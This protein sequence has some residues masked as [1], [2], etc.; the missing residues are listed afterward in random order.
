MAKNLLIATL[1]T[2]PAV[3]TEAVDL[4]AEQEIRLDG[5]ILFV[6]QDRDV[7]DSFQLLSEHLPSHDGINRN[8][9]QPFPVAAYE[10]IRTSEAAVE[11]MQEACHILKAYR[12]NGDRLFVC[13][14]GGRKAMSSL[15]VLAAQFYGAE[16][17]FHIWAPPWMEAEGEIGRLRNLQ[18]EQLNKYLH[19]S[20]SE[21][22]SDRPHIVVL[23]FIGLFPLLPDILNAFKGQTS[24]SKEVKAML[25]GNGLLTQGGELTSLGQRVA[26]ILDHVENLP[27]ARQSEYKIHIA[28]HHYRDKL[29]RFA[30]KLA[31]RF[32]FVTEIRSGEWQQGEEQVKPEPPSSLI[33]STRLGTDILFRLR[34]VTT[35][36]SPGQ[37]EAA[38]Q[39]VESYLKAI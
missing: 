11:F 26:K 1:G 36:R 12:D 31:E 15:L 22:E 37:L 30:K 17:L 33:V 2:S 4:L 5:V 29:E 10:D 25:V 38:R 18:P 16:R 35:A 7:M 8:R 20:L 24:L 3:I 13:I 21:R 32:F 19:P 27:P 39:S 28:S 6:T 23:P 14:A 9:I 34:L